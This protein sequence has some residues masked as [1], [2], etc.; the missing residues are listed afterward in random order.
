MTEIRYN[1]R[2]S[3]ECAELEKAMDS[4]I[5]SYSIEPPNIKIDVFNDSMLNRII[6]SPA[7]GN[8]IFSIDAIYTSPSCGIL[9]RSS[10][11]GV[12][13]KIDDIPYEIKFNPTNEK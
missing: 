4:F 8:K 7:L 5:Q 13:I 9:S 10:L 11:E 1:A 12:I 2:D 6:I 3:R